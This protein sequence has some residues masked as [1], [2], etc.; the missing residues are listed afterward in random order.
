VEEKQR[1]SGSE[2]ARIVQALRETFNLLVLRLTP[3]I[4][5]ATVFIAIHDSDQKE[6]TA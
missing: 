5:P 3:E 2:N 6:P 1:L 4:E